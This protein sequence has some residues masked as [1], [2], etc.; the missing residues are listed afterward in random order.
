MSMVFTSAPG[1]VDEERLYRELAA[2]SM[3]AGHALA[4]ALAREPG[5]SR[6]LCAVRR[7]Q[8]V[9]AP[10]DAGLVRM[11]R[12]AAAKAK[13]SGGHAAW[14][15]RANAALTDGVAEAVKAVTPTN[16]FWSVEKD[17]TAMDAVRVRVLDLLESAP[18]N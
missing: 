12:D 10:W 15:A 11:L 4:E 18:R 16:L 8:V 2:G 17:R 6:D 5:R 9:L 1:S 7:R 14:V 13:P 3:E